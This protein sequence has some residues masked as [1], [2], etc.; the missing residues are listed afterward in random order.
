MTLYVA[1]LGAKRY[2]PLLKYRANK[3]TSAGLLNGSSLGPSSTPETHAS[4]NMVQQAAGAM[5][6]VDDATAE[7]TN[8]APGPLHQQGAEDCK[9]E[10]ESKYSQML[11]TPKTDPRVLRLSVTESQQKAAAALSPESESSLHDILSF[12]GNSDPVLRSASVDEQVHKRSLMM[13][14]D[15]PEEVLCDHTKSQ[16]GVAANRRATKEESKAG[17]QQ[18]PAPESVVRK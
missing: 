10:N 9:T 8:R 16:G 5:M 11:P 6:D 17:D 13:Q 4:T 14:D 2:V 18:K 1:N 12:E 15:H 3:R 7:F